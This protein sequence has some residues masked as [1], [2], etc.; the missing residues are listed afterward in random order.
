MEVA[1]RSC[2]NALATFATYI[3]NLLIIDTG[4]NIDFDGNT[5]TYTTAATTLLTGRFDNFTLARTLRTRLRCGN[6]TE[7]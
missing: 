5:F 1:G 4:R 3:D 2:V 7:R 6:N